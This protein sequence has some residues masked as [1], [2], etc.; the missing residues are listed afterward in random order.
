[1]AEYKI[2]SRYAKSIVDL[3][4]ER[5]DLENVHNDFQMVNEALTNSRELVLLLQSPIVKPTKK[6]AIFREIFSGKFTS[7]I[8]SNFID[9]V[10]RKGREA[11]LPEIC[12]YIHSMY[13]DFNKVSI[14]TLVSAVELDAEQKSKIH[15]IAEQQIG[16]KVELVTQVDASLIS[17]FILKV[18]DTQIDTSLSNQFRKLRNEFDDNLFVKKY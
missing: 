2:S 5:N 3:A 10:I 16:R 11:N 17:G 13:N 12:R 9:I 18:G 1:M 15:A 14:A 7:D 4:I 8:A 6:T